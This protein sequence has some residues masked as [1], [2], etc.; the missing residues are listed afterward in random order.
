[1]EASKG[2]GHFGVL[3]AEW[4]YGGESTGEVRRNQRSGESAGS[5]PPLLGHLKKESEFFFWDL[6]GILF[7]APNSTFPRNPKTHTHFMS[8]LPIFKFQW[9][10]QMGDMVLEFPSRHTAFTL[11]NVRFACTRLTIPKEFSISCKVFDP[12]SDSRCQ[13]V[14]KMLNLLDQHISSIKLDQKC[15]TNHMGLVSQ[16]QNATIYLMLQQIYPKSCFYTSP[17]VF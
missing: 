10:S 16:A 4:A 13:E 11:V 8:P 15:F 9:N 3:R 2:P 5:T 1:M 17:A 14:K 12:T 7:L 6:L